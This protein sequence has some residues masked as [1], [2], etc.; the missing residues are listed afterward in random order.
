MRPFHFRAQAALDL[1]RKQ[2]D[3]LRRA[4]AAAQ[5]AHEA[6]QARAV[7]ADLNARRAAD[8]FVAEQ[9]HGTA[10]W[11]LGWHQSWIAKLRLEADAC[12]R[13]SAISAATVERATASVIAAFQKRRTLE[14]LRDRARRR[15][16][17]AAARQHNQD[18]NAFAGLRFSARLVE[19]GGS[20][21]DNESDL[22]DSIDISG[23]S[24][25]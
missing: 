21:S 24:V 25:H 9:R 10:A 3:E 12:Q 4:L 15:Y 6:A 18:M 23:R 17:T 1:R 5:I 22:I 11:R 16:D 14:R 19:R 2:E 20:S 8:D 7:A 13:A